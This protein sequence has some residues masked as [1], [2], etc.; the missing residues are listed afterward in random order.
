MEITDL[1]IV[2]GILSSLLVMTSV[3]IGLRIISKYFGTKRKEFIYFGITWILIVQPWYPSMISF[4][5]V[6]SG[7]DM[8]LS[9]YIWIEITVVW[10]LL[11]GIAALTEVLYIKYQERVIIIFFLIASLSEVLL[12][13]LLLI[14]PTLIG[15]LKD[16]MIIY[17]PV[18]LIFVFFMLIVIFIAGIL[19]T[20][21][22]IKADDKE[23]R[24]KGKLLTIAFFL[25]PIGTSIEVLL[26]PEIPVLFVTRTI[27]ILSA[28]FFYCG[29]FLP[30]FIKKRL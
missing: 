26:P 4:F 10:S 29:F 6:L 25:F 15:T 30:N 5:V 8:N 27:L 21:K 1:L 3:M 14:D 18:T 23:I 16:N 2:N 22:S 24:I 7:G 17:T 19:F 13:S 9:Q 11:F 12:I 20:T 28:I